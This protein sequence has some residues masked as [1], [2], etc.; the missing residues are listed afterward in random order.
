MVVNTVETSDIVTIWDNLF[1][2]EFLPLPLSLV[3][4]SE[5]SGTQNDWFE[6][7]MQTEVVCLYNPRNYINTS[8]KMLKAW[9]NYIFYFIL[10][11]TIDEMSKM[12]PVL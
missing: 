6:C 5:K 4:M 7:Y 1:S 11:Y 12:L 8:Y 2:F 10:R 9:G 3:D